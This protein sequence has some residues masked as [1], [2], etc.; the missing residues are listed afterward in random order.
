[1]KL[2]TAIARQLLG[3]ISG[4]AIALS[5]SQMKGHY[6]NDLALSDRLLI[7]PAE[8]AEMLGTSIEEIWVWILSRQISCY[9][10][11]THSKLDPY[12]ICDPHEIRA[13]Y[14]ERI[15]KSS[16]PSC[17]EILT[18]RMKGWRMCDRTLS[19]RLLNSIQEVA[20]RLKVSTNTV[21]EWI[22]SGELNGYGHGQTTKVDPAEALAFY[23]EKYRKEFS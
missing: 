15:G 21:W 20:W 12:E 17:K 19:D 2:Q 7:S 16:S 4:F 14:K 8:A 10:H 23:K 6:V 18:P 13:S 5:C 22:E 9:G 11:N 3:G 1:M